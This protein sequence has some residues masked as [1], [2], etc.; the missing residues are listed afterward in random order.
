[1]KRYFIHIPGWCYA[2]MCYGNNE[3]DARKRFREQHGFG[4]RMPRGTAVW[5]VK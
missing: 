3:R 2:M 1:M 5:E 4:D